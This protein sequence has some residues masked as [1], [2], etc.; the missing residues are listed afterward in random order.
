MAK[1][2]QEIG[3]ETQEKSV[4]DQVHEVLKHKV[5]SIISTSDLAATGKITF[6]NTG[7]IASA[8]STLHYSGMIRYEGKQGMCYQ[9]RVL[10]N[11]ENKRRKGATMVAKKKAPGKRRR[12]SKLSPLKRLEAAFDSL[13]AAIEHAKLE[14]LESVVEIETENEQLAEIREKV[15]ALGL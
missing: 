6:K 3:V 13:E 10:P 15:K 1:Q 5:G 2:K 8:L 12:K 7:A 11:I 4:V 14:I 9:Y